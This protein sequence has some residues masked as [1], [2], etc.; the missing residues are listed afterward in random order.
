[1]SAGTRPGLEIF[2]Q[3]WFD[4]VATNVSEPLRSPVLEICRSFQMGDAWVPNQL[5]KIIQ[6]GLAKTPLTIVANESMYT[7]IAVEYEIESG[8]WHYVARCPETQKTFW[9]PM[10]SIDGVINR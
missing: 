3:E 5:A 8:A 7:V 1:M 4:E 10:D 2:S 9:F 6:E